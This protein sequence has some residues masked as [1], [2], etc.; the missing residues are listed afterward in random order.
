MNNKIYI[1]FEWA[2]IENNKVITK[3]CN[4]IFVNDFVIKKL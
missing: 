4:I 1:K 2:G 3:S